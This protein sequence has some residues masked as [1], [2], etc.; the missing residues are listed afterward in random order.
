V[1]R[2]N[3]NPT[4][5]DI[6]AAAVCFLTLH[7]NNNEFANA[8]CIPGSAGSARPIPV[9]LTDFSNAHAMGEGCRAGEVSLVPM[10]REDLD[11]ELRE[12]ADSGWLKTLVPRSITGT[13]RLEIAHEAWR[14]LAQLDPAH[15][16]NLRSYAAKVV[17]NVALDLLAGP[18]RGVKHV[19]A[20]AKLLERTH[21]AHGSVGEAPDEAYALRQRKALVDKAWLELPRLRRQILYLTWIEEISAPEVA[22]RLNLSVHTVY[23]ERKLALAQFEKL[24]KKWTDDSHPRRDK[25]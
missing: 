10:S 5:R 9:E 25:S 16:D 14:R 13:D 12:W 21:L 19:E 20:T 7:S 1:Q 17:K 2:G 18:K 11:A 3:Y 6:V 15:I 22:R 23:S 4:S 8:A 24:I